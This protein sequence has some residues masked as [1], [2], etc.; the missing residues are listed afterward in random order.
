MF[1]QRHEKLNE[2]RLNQNV[3][4]RVIADYFLLDPFQVS[5]KDTGIAVFRPEKTVFS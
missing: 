3:H 2:Q 5:E 1:I 4:G